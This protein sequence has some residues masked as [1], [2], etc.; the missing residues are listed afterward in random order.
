MLAPPKPPSHD[1]PEALIKEAR[2]RQLRRRLLGAAGVAIVAAV[3][4]WAYALTIGRRTSS[5]GTSITSAAVLACRSS[6]LSTSAMFGASG[7][8]TFNP[9]QLTNT[10]GRACALPAGR[11]A[12]QIMFRGKPFPIAQQSWR[13]SLSPW[14]APAGHT[15]A[16]GTQAFVELR[17]R[18][19]C[20]RP[21]QAPTT[22]A[23]TFI[24]RFGGGLLVTATQSAPD[25]PGP[26][27]PGCGEVAHPRQ[28]VDIS[29]LLRLR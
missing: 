21:A 22:G 28:A 13:G 25:V 3:A 6:Q 15:L 29:P 4:L 12:L 9:V 19:W 7:G 26:A 5:S 14:G 23:V 8:T 2:E 11:P 1:E 17:W 10:S 18:D 24:L 20:P 27:L 16:A